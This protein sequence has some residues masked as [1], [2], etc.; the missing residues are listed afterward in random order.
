MKIKT[1]SK[2]I[3]FQLAGTERSGGKYFGTLLPAAE[4]RLTDTDKQTGA[5][6]MGWS[7]SVGC[8]AH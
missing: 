8:D 2:Q 6:L 7:V 5:N 1:G 3:N 4:F